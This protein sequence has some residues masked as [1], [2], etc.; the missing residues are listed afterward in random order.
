MPE[1]YL[2]K[3]I[4]WR[5]EFILNDDGSF[6]GGQG[7]RGNGLWEK[8]NDDLILKWYHWGT[9]RLTKTKKGYQSDKLKLIHMSKFTSISFCTTCKGRIGHLQETLPENI[10]TA[11]KYN[12][13][14]FVLLDYNSEDG[15]E[16]WIREEMMP[17]I[18]SGKLVYYKTTE[19]KFFN[20]SHAKNMVHRLATNDVVCNLD[21]DN[22]LSDEFIKQLRYEF[23]NDINVVLKPNSN[24]KGNAGRIS[25]SRENFL[26][27]RGYD[28][29][30][31][32]WG[33]EDQD[34]FN[35]CDVH[36]LTAI[37][38]KDAYSIPHTDR[39][40]GENYEVRD[41]RRTSR[42]NARVLRRRLLDGY[43]VSNMYDS[44]GEG[45]VTKNF[46]EEIV[47]DHI[48]IDTAPAKLY[49]KYSFINNY[50][51]ENECYIYFYEGCNVFLKEMKGNH[52]GG[53]SSY[54]YEKGTWEI[55][56]HSMVLKWNNRDLE[57]YTPE[58]D[59]IFTNDTHTLIKRA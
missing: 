16:E 48:E 24:L 59:E 20:M 45:N 36:G 7:Q 11:S 31:N 57:I 38:V 41:V 21:A 22:L 29:S 49:G 37:K 43:F 8:D 5:G 10:E 46:K 9:Q 56:N 39:V 33:N 26:K 42:S 4:K 52:I 17:F 30:A 6:I 1:R 54:W 18:E 12:N 58:G 34:F 53:I 40:R 2:A 50:Q 32:G 19:P 13:I 25:L 27:L 3:H 47:L 55:S 15:L 44:F 14:E 28:E 51:K 23:S 35:K